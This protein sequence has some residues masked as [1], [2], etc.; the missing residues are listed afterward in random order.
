MNLIQLEYLATTERAGSFSAAARE[1]FV[2]PQTVSKAL[3]AL[4]AELGVSL[5]ARSGRQIT[6]TDEGRLLAGRARDVLAD[7]DD[8][9][10]VAARLRASH[11]GVSGRLTVA[12]ASEPIRGQ[13]VPGALLEAFR[14]VHPDVELTCLANSSEACLD[15]VRYGIADAA[16]TLGYTT[17]SGLSWTRLYSFAFHLTL[18]PG[19]PLVAC[20]RIRMEDLADVLVATPTD[21]RCSYRI[22]KERGEE[23]GVCIRYADVP[24]TE[25]AH[26]AFLEDGGVIFTSAHPQLIET[27]PEL[28]VR[29]FEPS[30]GVVIPVCLVWREDERSPA[31]SL[32]ERCLA[33]EAR[34]TQLR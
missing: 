34:R 32:L 13:L 25:E 16:V 30:G 21:F 6:L 17:R 1:L 9:R 29:P 11:A 24:A 8:L 20:S 23:H 14:A 27:Y 33:Q 2:T 22:I 26:R 12:V 5:F 28:A 18:A 15:A 19:N 10:S 7:A 3:G 4:E 31:L